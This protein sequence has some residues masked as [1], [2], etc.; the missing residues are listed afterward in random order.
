MRN[1]SYILSCNASTPQVCQ[2]SDGR[3]GH[4][5]NNNAS[6]NQ[7]GVNLLFR[8]RS[9]CDTSTLP[10]PNQALDVQRHGTGV[11]FFNIVSKEM[12]TSAR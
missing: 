11:C 8:R 1:E 3:A 12:T 7:L 10:P 6:T 4:K 5:N 9:Q 2:K